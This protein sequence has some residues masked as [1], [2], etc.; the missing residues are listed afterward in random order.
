MHS[1]TARRIARGCWL[2]VAVTAL[3]AA[4]PSGSDV[5]ATHEQMVARAVSYLLTKGRA[6]DGSY[7]SFSGPGVT[8]LV[9][10]GLLKHGRSPD[11]PQVAPS[12]K[13][14]Q[15]FVQPDGG[16]YQPGSNHKNYE[17]CL[18]ILCFSEANRDGRFQELLKKAQAFITEGQWDDGEGAQVSD[19]A[20]GGAGYG[21]SKRPDLSNT[22]FFLDAL[23]AAETPENSDAFRKALIFV[24]RCQNL[25]SEH[26][27]TEFPAKN[28]DGGFYYTVAAGGSSMAGK[29][30][31]GGLR[32]YGSMT[33]AGLKSMIYAGVKQDDPRVKAAVQ[34]IRDHYDLSANPGMGQAGLYYYYQTFAKALDAMKIDS[35]QDGTGAS[36]AWRAELIEELAKRQQSDGSW[37]NTTDR[38]L[39]GD[40]NLVTGYVLLALSHC[41]PQ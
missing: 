6:A 1:A 13:Y 18:A 23:K 33:Y 41:R 40:A 17:T 20:Y 35:L 31:N 30:D 10:A 12:L 21:R 27:L 29:T 38:W 25:E 4:E 16:I 15:Q 8:A 37:V 34:W 26:N 22:S 19:V 24:S 11:D 28:P 32:S 7:S 5:R 9:T 36:H 2:F 14:L 39:E 3:Q